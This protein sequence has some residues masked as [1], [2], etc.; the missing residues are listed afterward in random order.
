M[1]ENRG[2]IGER[3]NVLRRSLNLTQEELSRMAGI[4][5]VSLV[6]IE[7][8]KTKHPNFQTMCKIAEALNADLRTF[9]EKS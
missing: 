3:I 4:S 7:Q 1:N 8:G 5:Y 6:K 2:F 9:I